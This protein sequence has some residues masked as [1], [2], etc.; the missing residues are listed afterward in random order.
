M[1]FSMPLFL[2]YAS[3]SL[4]KSRKI[5]DEVWGWFVVEILLGL[6]VVVAILFFIPS[7][8]II[9]KWNEEKKI[10][11]ILVL[12]VIGIGLLF[13]FVP[14][15]FL[16]CIV[17]GGLL[18]CWNLQGRNKASESNHTKHYFSGSQAKRDEGKSSESSN[19]DTIRTNEK[20]QTEK[21]Q[22]LQINL[23]KSRKHVASEVPSMADFMRP[24]LRWASEQPGE[25][26]LRE[27][28]GA[29]A[30]HFKLSLKAKDELTE[31]GNVD[32]VYD[33]TSWSINPHLKE[34]GLVY[35][36]RRGY[37]KIT[38]AGEKEAF[39]SNERMTTNYL[40]DNFPSYRDWKENKKNNKE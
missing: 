31:E 40:A 1:G 36:M 17:I 30:S 18:Y 10:V 26:T 4:R 21:S 38:E 23:P 33:R 35:S 5:V 7:F 34:A 11:A 19:T 16:A 22:R 32:R 6:A 8:S 28:T 20:E 13:I 37:W 9:R 12:L 29:M 39:A 14:Q 24:I 25:F 15:L 3:P 2:S 27:A